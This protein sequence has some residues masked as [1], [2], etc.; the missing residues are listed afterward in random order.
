MN[1]LVKPS[2]PDDLTYNPSEPLPQEGQ[3]AT[4]RKSLAILASVCVSLTG[5]CQQPVDASIST[6]TTKTELVLV[7][8]VVVDRSGKHIS[9]LTKQDFSVYED[10][11]ERKIAFFE[12]VRPRPEKHVLWREENVYSNYLGGSTTPAR[13]TIFALDMVNT[14]FMGQAEARRVLLEILAK[15]VDDGEPK[16]VVVFTGSGLQVMHDF[17]TEPAVLARALRR[18]RG[19]SP[20]LLNVT[21][22]PTD[23]LYRKLSEFTQARN[24]EYNEF[25]QRAAIESTDN[26]LR[27]IATAFSG[28]PGR[29]ALLWAT[30]GFPFLM[31][32]PMQ[33][34]KVV[35]YNVGTQE[36]P[37]Y[38]QTWRMLNSANVAVYPIDV[39]EVTIPGFGDASVQSLSREV[40]AWRSASH[41]QG[42]TTMVNYARETGGKSCIGRIDF[43]GCF[44]EAL[45]ESESY[46][47]IGY[48]LDKTVKPGWHKL[49]VKTRV[50]DAEIR[51]RTGVEVPDPAHRIEIKNEF[52]L[53]L[54]SPMIYTG[55]PMSVKWMGSKDRNNEKKPVEFELVLPPG[56]FQIDE[57]DGNHMKIELTAIGTNEK[58]NASGLR[59]KVLE[60]R[61]KQ[62]S[63]SK[64][65]RE[66]FVYRNTVEVAPGEHS[67]R[68]VVRD[69][70]TG[71]IGSVS[72]PL[73][74]E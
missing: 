74:A 42:T 18:F 1:R 65:R 22:S 53:A 59:G 40:E 5:F 23:P 28:V 39:R 15:A 45:Q 21:A 27:Q 43:S 49:Q 24:T 64:I 47:M 68:F 36:V 38:E 12:E 70:L 54:L 44:D 4:L 11:Q 7:P 8:A 14:P 16:A 30:A 60:A 62:E 52:E 73:K 2:T 55:I 32:S 35:G 48:Y 25:Q 31:L 6:F 34:G 72:A 67:V 61:F 37:R 10:R 57:A 56:G 9:N 29:K 46:Y 66:G 71:R 51:A 3:R 50:R 20:D 63:A 13:L 69:H 41:E 33:G 26:C 58:G 19:K 17:T